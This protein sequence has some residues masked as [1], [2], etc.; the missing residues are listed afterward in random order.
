MSIIRS[1]D[2]EDDNDGIFQSDLYDIDHKCFFC[3]EKITFPFIYWHGRYSKKLGKCKTLTLHPS[4]AH[5]LSSALVRDCVE[6]ITGDGER[7][8]IDHAD[9]KN[10]LKE[11]Y[12]IK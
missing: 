7:A 11:I 12:G 5:M 10:M 4:C 9:R 2:I 1:N 6:L 3:Q 8:N